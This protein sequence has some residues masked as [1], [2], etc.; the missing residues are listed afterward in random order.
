MLKR[1]DLCLRMR[2]DLFA[3]GMVELDALFRAERY[4]EDCQTV[5]S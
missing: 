5:Y 4:G 2:V 3:G 1:S